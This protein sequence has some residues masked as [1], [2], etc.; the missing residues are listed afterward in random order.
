MLQ[1][2]QPFH[3]RL[4]FGVQYCAGPRVFALGSS[5]IVRAGGH[6][7]RGIIRRQ[8]PAA[9]RQ[10]QALTWPVQVNVVSRPHGHLAAYKVLLL[11]L[12]L[13]HVLRLRL[14]ALHGHHHPVLLQLLLVLQLP[15]LKLM[16]RLSLQHLL[17]L[18]CLLCIS[19]VL[20]RELQLMLLLLL[21][22]VLIIASAG[23]ALARLALR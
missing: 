6:H 23:H 17:P 15:L 5:L 9:S 14:M 3:W 1:L 16:T 12:L 20:R 22:L 10:W 13:Q 2:T 19:M 11:L 4:H 8:S 18:W 7:D 21:R